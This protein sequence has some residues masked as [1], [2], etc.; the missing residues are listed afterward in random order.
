MEEVKSK[1][2]KLW[3]PATIFFNLIQQYLT[4]HHIHYNQVMGLGI[5]QL[6]IQE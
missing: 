4:R 2:V 6:N 3:W 1:V 5:W